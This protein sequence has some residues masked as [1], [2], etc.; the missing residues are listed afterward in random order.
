M[1]YG[2]R[3]SDKPTAAGHTLVCRVPLIFSL[4]L[5]WPFT[6]ALHPFLYSLY[7]DPSP[8]SGLSLTVHGPRRKVAQ[9]AGFANGP[10]RFSRMRGQGIH[11][12]LDDEKLRVGGSLCRRYGNVFV[13]LCKHNRVSLRR[14]SSPSPSLL[15]H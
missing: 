15:G 6:G 7:Y 3:S 2:Q 9:Q 8:G 1:G 11:Q 4:Y 12:G 13:S 14:Q 5:T 10:A